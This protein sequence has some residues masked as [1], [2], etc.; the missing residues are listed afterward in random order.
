MKLLLLFKISL[1][2]LAI[3]EVNPIEHFLKFGIKEGRK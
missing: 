2:N 1:Q 3:A